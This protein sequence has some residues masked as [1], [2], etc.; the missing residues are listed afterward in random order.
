MRAFEAPCIKRY[1]REFYFKKQKLLER[2]AEERAVCLSETT[3]SLGQTPG[4]QIKQ[5]SPKHSVS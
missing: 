4:L 2:R 5:P 3:L 1:T